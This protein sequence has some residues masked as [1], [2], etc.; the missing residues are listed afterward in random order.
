MTTD[1]ALSRHETYLIVN[2]D[3]RDNPTGPVDNTAS[4]SKVK[5]KE[6]SLH[7]DNS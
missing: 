3:N 6:N 7:E 2:L 5:L 4:F 1:K